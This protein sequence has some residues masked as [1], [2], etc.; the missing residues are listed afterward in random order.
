MDNMEAYGEFAKV[1]DIFQDN[2]HYEEWADYLCE[3]LKEYGIENGLVLELGCGTGTMTELLAEA[4]YDMIGV[5]N[6]EEMLAEAAAK[7]IERG[8]IASE[9]VP[10]FCR[11]ANDPCLDRLTQNFRKGLEEGTIVKGDDGKYSTSDGHP[12]LLVPKDVA[13]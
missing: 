3:R 8:D 1:Y 12:I 6:S 13:T 7:F 11:P 5:D 4:G 9:D 10:V 2:I